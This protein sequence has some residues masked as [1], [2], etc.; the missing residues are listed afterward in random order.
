MGRFEF[1]SLKKINVGLFYQLPQAQKKLTLS[2]Y[3]TLLRIL[4]SPVIVVMMMHGAW[5]MACAL[6]IS[7]SLTDTLD[8]TLARLRD[9]KTFLGACLDPIADKI[10]IVSS[11]FTLAFFQSPLFAIP[12]W[13]VYVVLLKE[14]LQISGASI[15]YFYKGYLEVEPTLLG[16]VTTVAQ[17][18]FISWLFACYFFQWVPMKTYYGM[19][20]L[21]MCL[22]MVTFAQYVWIGL[23][24]MWTQD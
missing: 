24:S 18:G 23:R 5:G 14:V 13:F 9:E 11:F 3:I 16:K 6:F 15:L 2:S 7:A 1:K 19:L 8:G 22:I 4:L 10:L 12:Q 20:G 17:M 21:L